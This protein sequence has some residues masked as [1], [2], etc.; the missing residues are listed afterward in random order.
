[1]TAGRGTLHPPREPGSLG[2]QRI[3][4]ARRTDTCTRWRGR[5]RPWP[6][7]ARARAYAIGVARN[8][9]EVRCLTSVRAVRSR[10][11]SARRSRSDS[12]R[13]VAAA[14]RCDG[15]P[16]PRRGT[17]SSSCPRS[18]RSSGS[19]SR[20]AI[21]STS[22]PASAT[23]RSVAAAALRT[24]SSTRGRAARPLERTRGSAP[25]RPAQ[26]DGQNDRKT[27]HGAEHRRSRRGAR[28]SPPHQKSSC[29][30]PTTVFIPTRLV[31]RDRG[32]VL[33]CARRA[34]RSASARAGGGRG[35]AA[36]ARA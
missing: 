25:A 34:S 17:P 12:R 8:I 19:L 24:R 5:A 15:R 26:S 2:A 23:G 21:S 33:G 13:R 10:A 6:P 28:G 1:M 9:D 11:R 29:G 4:H 14:R 7:L 20:S 18:R 22:S 3:L 16:A 32:R 30:T 27:P 35:R 36:R 31:E